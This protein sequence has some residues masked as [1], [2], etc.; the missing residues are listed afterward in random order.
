MFLS[1]EEGQDPRRTKI[2]GFM[3]GDLPIFI[4]IHTV[5]RQNWDLGVSEPKD[6]V[7]ELATCFFFFFFNCW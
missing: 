3:R 4:H 5:K 7:T 1:E 6:L 2:N